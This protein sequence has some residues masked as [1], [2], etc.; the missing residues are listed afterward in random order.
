MESIAVYRP[1]T[2]KAQDVQE[3][4]AELFSDFV[5]FIDRSE[6]TTRTHITNLRQFMAW[7]KYAAI[8]RPARQDIISYREYLTNEHDAISFAPETP[9]GWIYRTNADGNP[10]KVTCKATTVKGYLQ[11]VKQF[12][13]WTASNGYYPNI[14]EN[15]HTPK[16]TQDHKKDSLTAADVLTI[17]KSISANAEAKAETASKAKKDTAGRLSRATEQGK[18]LYAMYLLAVNAG[19]RTVEISRLN[20]KDVEAVGGKAFI[21]VWGKGHAEPDQ[22]KPI[23]PEVKTAIDDYLQIRSDSKTG[24]SPLFV[25][26][27]NRSGGKRLAPTTISTMLKRAMQTAGYDSDRITA[28]SLRHT[29][30]ANVMELT[31][32]NIYKAQHYLRHQSP[33]TTEIYLSNDTEKQD[34]DIA[35]KLFNH[36]H[37]I[38]TDDDTADLISMIQALSP[39]QISIVKSLVSNFN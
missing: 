34:A 5:S 17:E 12:F 30:A 11:S 3:I 26:T 37:D 23:A 9:S 28:H 33:H 27:G 1:Y 19:L 29:T 4:T 39:D 8:T 35:Q 10:V 24:G 36:Y 7:L 2:L 15:V 32:N 6:R 25:A 38:K 13:K 16:I 14:A 18:R 20:I 21:Y 31:D 22:K